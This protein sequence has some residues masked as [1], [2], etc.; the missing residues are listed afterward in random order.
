MMYGTEYFF[1]SLSLFPHSLFY[2]SLAHPNCRD[3]RI[4]FACSLFV[5]LRGESNREIFPESSSSHARV[6]NRHCGRW[7]NYCLPENERNYSDK[8]NPRRNVLQRLIIRNKSAIIYNN[9][10]KLEI[11]TATKSRT[12]LIIASKFQKVMLQK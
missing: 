5:G 2:E 9:Q 1:S 10:R 7:E 12:C 11:I 4:A 8:R 6:P 3:T